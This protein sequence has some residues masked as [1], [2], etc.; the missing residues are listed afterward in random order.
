MTSFDETFDLAVQNGD[1][2][3]AVMLAKSKSGSTILSKAIGTQNLKP[4]DD[5]PYTGQSVMLLASL[6]KLLTSIAALQLVERGQVTLD[7]DIL[8]LLPAFAALDIFHGYTADGKPILTKRHNPVTLR[9]LL[10]HSSGA[11][12]SF[13]LD[14]PLA[15]Y[16]TRIQGRTL[17]NGD[18]IDTM[19]DYPL[20]FEAGEGWQYGSS[21]D[22]VG[23]VIE[24]IS[25]QSLEDFFAANIYAPLGLTTG[26]FWPD[27]RR[28]LD[29]HRAA[30]TYRSPE[31][32]RVVATSQEES[33]TD[34][35]TEP[36]GGHG[37]FMSADDYLEVLHSLL[38]DDE[39]LLR[40]KT[41]ALMFRGHL[42]AASRARLGE[43]MQNA[44]WTVGDFP[45][46]MEYDWGFGGMLIDGAFHDYHRKGTLVWGGAGNQYWFIDR[47]SGVS[48]VLG[49]QV[50]PSGDKKV[51]KLL[52]AFQKEVYERIGK[53][54]QQ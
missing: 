54:R 24:A 22:R 20:L 25:G 4:G 12:Y 5:T 38:A 6:T 15:E 29:P 50:F 40:R 46:S 41:S 31:T 53:G 17:L 27:R 32:G 33:L 2:A 39:R 9:Q 34:G 19:F 16:R 11:A 30:L 18:T 37:L 14:S 8:P 45:S 51:E 48:A 13:T 47:E 10:T 3:G 26:T 44:D 21:I 43:Q 42:S 52:T 35:L 23:Q 49:T 28:D 36:F 7:Q 1:I